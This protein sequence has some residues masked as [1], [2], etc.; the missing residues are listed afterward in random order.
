[1]GIKERGRSKFG[2]SAYFVNVFLK[3]GIAILYVLHLM[4]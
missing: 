2:A 1:M 4:L 3:T